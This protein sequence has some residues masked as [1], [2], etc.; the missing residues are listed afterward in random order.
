MQ[1][2]LRNKHM[3]K[4]QKPNQSR[5]HNILNLQLQLKTEIRT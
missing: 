4:I 3:Y 1:K 2:L 5:F